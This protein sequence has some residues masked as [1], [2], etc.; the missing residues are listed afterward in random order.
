MSRA[1]D[2]NVSTAT[3]SSPTKIYPGVRVYSDAQAVCVAVAKEWMR[4]A[5]EAIAMRG[6]FHIALA[7]GTTPQRLYERLAEPDYAFRPEWHRTFVYFGDERAVPPDHEQSNYHMATQALLGRVSIPP[8]QVYR[9]EAERA[10]LKKAAFDYSRT[11]AMTLPQ[12][13][14][15]MPRFD[16][17][18]LGMGDDGHV[19][20]LFPGSEE[21]REPRKLVVP[22]HAQHLKSWRLS[23]T[24]PVINHARRVIML[25][26]GDTKASMVYRALR[27]I[28]GQS[29]QDP[30]PVQRVAPV[31]GQLEWRLDQKAAALL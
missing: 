24:F 18:L 15:G 7:G 8:A 2:L 25:I 3:T 12:A 6:V 29:G 31:S 28:P 11:L 9:M 27:E 16:L 17:V 19:A 26:C 23:L 10:D 30:L 21:V 22:V 5:Q 20:S 13:K 14:N 1:E 4:L